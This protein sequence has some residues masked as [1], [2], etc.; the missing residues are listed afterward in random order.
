[1][2]T[3]Y[4]V[5]E[6]KL[7]HLSVSQV[8]KFNAA[9]DGCPL[10]WFY[11]NVLGKKEPYRAAADLG[12]NI[13]GEL[14]I[15]LPT[16]QNV[17]GKIARAGVHL[18]PQPGADL[19]VEWGFNNKPRPPKRDGK[20]VNYFPAQESL[21]WA[22]GI[23]FIGFIDVVNTRGE[24]LVP[25]ADDDRV[26]D[27]VS[28]P[29]AIE[30]L[31]HKSTSNFKWLKPSE[32]LIETTQMNGCGVF[33]AKADTEVKAVRLSHLGYK[34]EGAADSIKRSALVPREKILDRWT[35]VV[36][37]LVEKMKSV[38][39]TKRPEDVE[40]NLG[41]CEN[42]GGCPH[43][44]YCVKYQATTT[45]QRMSMSLLR[46]RPV[47]NGAAAAAPQTNT[48]WIPPQP[49][50]PPPPPVAAAPAA[51]APVAT[52]SK[53]SMIDA[54]DASVAVQ[55]SRYL[56]RGVESIFLSTVGTN[57]RYLQSF[58]P[59]IGGQPVLVEANEKIYSAPPQAAVAAPPPAPPVQAAPPPPTAPPV[60]AAPPP[61]PAYAPPQPP[62]PPAY[63][64]PAP[65]AAPAAPP[66]PAYAAPTQA[67]PPLPPPPPAGVAPKKRGRVSNAE[68]AAQAAAAG[69]T[70]SA[71][72]ASGFKLCINVI[73]N[74]PFQDLFGYV[75]E[76]T[77][78]L[79]AQFG[80]NDIRASPPDSPLAFA[81]WRGVLAELVKTDPPQPGTYFAQ[82]KGNEFVE[83]A[84]E[85]LATICPP[86]QL[87]RGV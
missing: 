2:G 13:H 40:A 72:S 87:Y 35:R 1:V 7:Q 34:T 84:A 37:P 28:E 59:I 17:L 4:T 55:G 68:K 32:K 56:V 15:Y 10:R 79:E 36:E 65:P 38:A 76:A 44:G 3:S 14:E 41:A 61:S 6:G 53:L 71:P 8:A 69:A 46:N 19:M 63:A 52:A 58:L 54:L 70:A 18:L 47:A 25:R 48:P 83:V 75:A 49:P 81:R 21:V 29:D 50:A 39:A 57:G 9:E 27:L 42:F 23:P 64:A 62:A 73:P 67:A 51:P 74:E 78:E 80:V 31:D 20:Q 22:A 85:A 30:V 77:K 16:G 43:K 12:T 82:T 11:V 24:Y 33:V 60:Q 5:I 26:V 86:G 45:L 66:A